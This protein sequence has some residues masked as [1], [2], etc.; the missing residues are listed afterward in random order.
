MAGQK[1]RRSHQC[2]H[3]STGDRRRVWSGA[4]CGFSLAR[5]ESGVCPSR[6]RSGTRSA[7]LGDLEVSR[8]SGLETTLTANVL[9]VQAESL[10][11]STGD[12][13][14]F[15]FASL[16][17]APSL[18]LRSHDAATREQPWH[19]S[20][21]GDPCRSGSLRRLDGLRCAVCGF[22]GGGGA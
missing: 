11:E 21:C 14:P 18:M 3:D 12:E 17:A 6:L 10:S 7:E 9:R 4:A 8:A 13:P 1:A 22:V 16:S 19:A 2:V 15:M 20:S 5:L